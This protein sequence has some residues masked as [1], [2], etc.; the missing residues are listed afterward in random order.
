MPSR[1][2]AGR[3]PGMEMIAARGSLEVGVGC[4]TMSISGLSSPV[5]GRGRGPK[6][7]LGEVRGTGRSDFT[8]LPL[9]SPLARVPSS[10]AGREKTLRHA[11]SL[12]RV[13]YASLKDGGRHGRCPVRW[14][15]LARLAVVSA[16][17]RPKSGRTSSQNG[18]H[19]GTPVLGNLAAASGAG[20]I[21]SPGLSA[22]PRRFQPR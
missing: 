17:Q 18:E 21:V 7:S 19:F 22:G 4:V 1:L 6:R 10:P 13:T 3:V 2:T 15:Q 14:C 8:P 12:A 20:I 16:K 5:Y 9:I 11:S